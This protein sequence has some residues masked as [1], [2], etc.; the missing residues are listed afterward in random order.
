V[1]QFSIPKFLLEITGLTGLL[2]H[3]LAGGTSNSQR[4]QDQLTEEI[5]RLLMAS[6]RTLKQKPKLLGNIRAQ[7]SHHSKP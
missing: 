4:E 3:R 1:P 5:T 6:A 2:T 7:F